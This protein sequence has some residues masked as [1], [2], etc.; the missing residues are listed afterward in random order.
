VNSGSPRKKNVAMKSARLNDLTP[1]ERS[2]WDALL[3][4][5]GDC[6]SP[7]LSYEFCNA[8]NDVCGN[9]FVAALHGEGRQ[10]LFPF[11][12]RAYL[13][14]IGDKVGGHMSDYCGLVGAYRGG[15]SERQILSA[16]GLSVF[17]FD[18]W[19]VSA[20]PISDPRTA[21][22]HG[23]KVVMES[24]PS[25]FS[26]LQTKDRKFVAEVARLERQLAG[27]HGELRFE[28]QA[29]KSQQELDKLIA[30]KRRQYSESGVSDALAPR[31]CR[32]LLAVLLDGSTTHF[33]AIISTLYSG[34][35]WVAS[36]FGLRYGDVLHIWF[37]VYN[38]ELRRFG[39]G[40]ILFFKIFSQ[41]NALGIREFD[42]GEGVS[43]YKKKYAGS[44]YAVSK[45][46]LRKPGP[47]AAV[48]RV[49]QSISWRMR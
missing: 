27:K 22:S 25:Y 37:P 33:E 4:S 15:F 43:S 42:F 10:A 16:T 34:N 30:E 35:T 28:W 3:A 17:C 39:P 5:G 2:K 47:T 14:G 11:Q 13:P 49:A 31:W 32:D 46:C 24:A 40:H 7:F 20:C 1:E 6:V 26:D 48:H 21:E 18:H 8:V 9:V 41:G 12:R 23:I 36:H 38:N 29:L 44:E 45:G 19:P